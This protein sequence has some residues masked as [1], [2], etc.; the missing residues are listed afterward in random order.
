MIGN[1]NQQIMRLDKEN[2]NQD[3]LINKMIKKIKSNDVVVISDYNK[4]FITSDV[5]KFIKKFS[6]NKKIPIFVDPKNYNFR[7]YNLRI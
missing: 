2:I 7:I 1:F 4:G 6:K 3:F 5:I